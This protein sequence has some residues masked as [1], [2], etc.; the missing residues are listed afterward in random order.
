MA[1]GFLPPQRLHRSQTFGFD[2]GKIVAFR[3]I[4]SDVVELPLNL[5]DA[6]LSRL[7][8]VVGHR[9]PA[10]VVDRTAGEHLEVLG[11]AVPPAC[12]AR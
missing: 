12:P 4:F 10:V 3:T 6:R 9:F 1:L 2:L 5:V 7:H 8:R 11:V